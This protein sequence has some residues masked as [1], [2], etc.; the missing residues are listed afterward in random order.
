MEEAGAHLQAD[1]KDEQDEAELL[2]EMDDLRIGPEAEMA[3]DDAHEQDPGG[4]DG[5]ALHLDS[6]QI[7]AD[8]DDK[9]QQQDRM[10][11]ARTEEQVSHSLEH[12]LDAESGLPV[13][14]S[15]DITD[16]RPV[17][18]RLQPK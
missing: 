7:D 6:T 17:L 5:N 12:H 14:A 3:D 11:D 8:A 4:A 10:G 9:R 16:R 18:L 2:D 15:F 1:G 13:H